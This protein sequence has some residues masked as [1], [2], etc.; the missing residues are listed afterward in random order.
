MA[1]FNRDYHRSDEEREEA[2]NALLNRWG[3]SPFSAVDA[4][5]WLWGRHDLATIAMAEPLLDRL[6]QNRPGWQRRAGYYLKVDPV[7]D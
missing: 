3:G 1:A 6:M 2:L 4:S 5:A 7:R